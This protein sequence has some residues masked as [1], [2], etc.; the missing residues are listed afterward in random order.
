M[1][2]RNSPW[3]LVGL[4]YGLLIFPLITENSIAQ[5]DICTNSIWSRMEE[6]TIQSND[7]LE[8]IASRYNL[9]PET[10]IRVNPS[11][12][13]RR[14]PPG[15]IMKI[16]PFNGMIINAPSGATWKDLGEAYGIRADLLFELN[17]CTPI[18]QQVF[19]PGITWTETNNPQNQN[20]YTEFPFYPLINNR[21]I[22]LNYGWQTNQ[23]NN[24]TFFHGG[25]DILANLGESVIA[26]E[27]GIVVFAG[28]Q[29]HYGNLIIINHNN[30][31]QTRYAHL[32]KINIQIGQMIQGGEIIGLV[33]NTGIPDLVSPHLHFEVR[34]SSPLGWVAQDPFLNFLRSNF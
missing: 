29:D 34:L 26:V 23:E 17:G 32:E 30:G 22:A 4:I 12:N 31:K 8:A 21:E 14:L 2:K 11:L 33:G 16:P 27:D 10:L 15:Q 7:T 5:T 3:G 24:T 6:Y 18:T 25:V 19:I 13:A 20:N 28:N 1:K 9:V